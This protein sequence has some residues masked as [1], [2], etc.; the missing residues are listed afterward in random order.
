MGISV[1]KIYIGVS[2]ILFVCNLCVNCT[3]DLK[4]TDN[5]YYR[6]KKNGQAFCKKCPACKGGGIGWNTTAERL[7]DEHGFRSCYPCAKCSGGTY[8]ELDSDDSKCKPCTLDCLRLRRYGSVRC[9]G[10]SPGHCGECMV[11]YKADSK[12]P[13]SMCT[14]KTTEELEKVITVQPETELEPRS[15]VSRE[16][17]DNPHE[18][19][20]SHPL[21]NLPVWI[22]AGILLFLILIALLCAVYAGT[23]RGQHSVTR[24]RL[25][26]NSD[27][28]L[29]ESKAA[30][31][32]S[33]SSFGEDNIEIDGNEKEKV[34]GERPTLVTIDE[35][36]AMDSA[37]GVTRIPQEHNKVKTYYDRVLGKDDKTLT[38]A[39]SGIHG[40]RRHELFHSYLKIEKSKTDPEEEKWRLEIISFP[41]YILEVLKIWLQ[42]ADKEATVKALCNALKMASFDKVVDE[43]LDLPENQTPPTNVEIKETIEINIADVKYSE[44]K[45]GFIGKEN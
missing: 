33:E 36:A 26:P 22:P 25:P 11:R 30:L 37:Y 15:S 28:A 27:K 35:F 14:I 4:C 39:A 31:I 43:I 2:A 5:T 19:S 24:N 3:N 45:F 10:A 6:V 34:R 7:E 23:R 38:M 16:K 12:E 1:R 20:A 17:N 44:N 21:A 32:S 13:N 29:V 41:A 42:Q 18:K 40:E 8:R 9:G